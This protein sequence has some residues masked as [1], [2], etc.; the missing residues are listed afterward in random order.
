MLIVVG[1]PSQLPLT[2]LR[3]S[4]LCEGT[5]AEMIGDHRTYKKN[6][7][8]E[9]GENETKGSPYFHDLRRWDIS[10]LCQLWK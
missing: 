9:E 2:L 1:D 3:G 7:S 4:Y 8:F 5:N 10:L 6:F